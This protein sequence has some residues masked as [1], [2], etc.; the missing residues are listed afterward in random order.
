MSWSRR[1]FVTNTSLAV[2]AA[3]LLPNRLAASPQQP[4]GAEPPAGPVFTP[5]RGGVGWATLGGGTVGWW[6]GGDGA[7]VVDSQVPDAAPAMLAGLKARTARLDLLI[8]T[9]HH[10]DH[11]GGNATFRPAVGSILAHA[12]VPA[13]QRAAAARFGEA[14]QVVAETTFTEGWARDFGA[15]QVSTRFFGA[16]HTGGDIAVLFEKAEVVH[17][18]D[19]V[20]NRLYPVIDRPGGTVLSG[21]IAVLDQVVATYGDALYIFGHA[22][23]EF[24]VTGGKADVI[25]H[26]NYL[27]ALLEHARARLAAGDS[28]DAIATGVQSL[29]GFGDHQARGERLSL[30]TNLRLAC[31]ELRG[32]PVDG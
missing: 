10:W 21:W 32:D 4:A 29:P 24:G 19:L 17:L 7:V 18:G 6:I 13:L 27:E 25:H 15:E 14:E 12:N 3:G 31:A 11:T 23:A 5:L 26:R 8:N 9:H 20:F 30:A 1:D 22:A 28:V 16:A 2:V